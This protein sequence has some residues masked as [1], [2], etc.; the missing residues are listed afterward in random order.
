MTAAAPDRVLNMIR[1][2]LRAAVRLAAFP[3]AV[4]LRLSTGEPIALLCRDAVRMPFG[5]VLAT[6]SA[7]LALD[8]LRGPVLAGASEVRIGQW[9]VR[10]SRLLSATAPVGLA[11]D[12]AA[13]EYA[14]GR[15]SRLH[16][17]VPDLAGLD[18]MP[19]LP[20]MNPL[21]F[22][23]A[24]RI[25]GVGPGLTPSGDDFLAGLLVGAWSFGL[26]ADTLR[27]E[28]RTHATS[29]TTE[30]SAALLRSACRG[31]SIPEL[32]ALLLSLSGRA[33]E[34]DDAFAALVKVGH[35]SG[36]ALAAGVITAATIATRVTARRAAAHPLEGWAALDSAALCLACSGDKDGVVG[37]GGCE[38]RE[39]GPA[40]WKPVTVSV[41]LDEQVSARSRS[42]YSAGQ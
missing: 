11:P 33:T 18:V 39:V 41:I 4:Y 3:S 16:L 7:E 9:S 2:P 36:Q 37:R 17:A 5:L 31:E 26:T 12:P 21:E 22:V 40:G 8:R 25:L 28:V 27:A 42:A 19:R 6:S 14:C 35:T 38:F 29:L 20:E 32:T 23:H 15:L 24:R 13:V 30:V 1:G 10:V 34:V